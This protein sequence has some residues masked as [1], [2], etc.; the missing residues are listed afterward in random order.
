MKLLLDENLYWRII[1]LIKAV[2]HDVIHVNRIEVQQP[3]KTQTF[4]SGLKL[5]K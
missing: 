5:M 2:F 4:G 3:A 1:K